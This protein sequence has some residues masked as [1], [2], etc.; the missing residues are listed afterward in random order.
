MAL[1]RLLFALEQLIPAAVS[2]AQRETGDT[3]TEEQLREALQELATRP[4]RKVR[5]PDIYTERD[6]G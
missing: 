6:D 3:I 5:L 2:I 1:A 4:P